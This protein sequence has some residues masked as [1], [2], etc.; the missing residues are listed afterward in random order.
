MTQPADDAPRVVSTPSASASA[1]G[2][3]R[4]RPCPTLDKAREALAEAG[5]EFGLKAGRREVAAQLVDSFMEEAKVVYVIY[6]VWTAGFLD[7]LAG[8][9]VSRRMSGQAEIVRL[10]APDGLSRTARRS[11]RRPAGRSWASL[12][13][14]L[15]NRHPRLRHRPWRTRSRCC[16]DLSEGWR[17]LHDRYADLMAGVLAYVARRFGEARLEDCYRAVLEPYIQE[18]YML[19]D[20]RV[21][22][23]RDDR[24]A[25]PLPRHGG[26]AGAPVR[27]GARRLAGVSR[28]TTTSVV[29]S[30]DPCG[31]GGR[32]MRGDDIEGTGSR[33]LAPYEFGVTQE[34]H[35]WAWNQEGICYY[36]AHCC[37]ALEKLPDGALGT[38]GPRRRPAALG[39][40][41]RTRRDTQAV[42]LDGLQDA[43]GDPGRGLSTGGPHQAPVAGDR[44]P[45]ALRSSRRTPEPPNSG[46]GESRANR[47]G[48][49]R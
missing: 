36:C 35:D 12:A 25:Q 2:T 9:G 48:S 40:L 38:P 47:P 43:R 21:T 30:F 41:P 45:A 6:K 42:H 49:R 27:T 23:Y 7:W 26:D 5:D 31:S 17:R 18:R 39:W 14:R 19:F 1:P 28:R 34:Q 8:Q 44:C 16:D 3:G 13:G 33:V 29:V 11:T 22:P 46:S 4:T 20:T 24:R 37:L 32:S 15:G 10:R